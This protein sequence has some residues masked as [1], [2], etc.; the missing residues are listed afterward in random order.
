[1]KE[2]YF[3]MKRRFVLLL[4]TIVALTAMGTTSIWAQE[5]LGV[6]VAGVEVTSANATNLMKEIVKEIGNGT[7]KI[8]YDASTFTLTLEGV[9]MAIDD[10]TNP[11][12]T[13]SELNNFIIELKGDN[14]ITS[15]GGRLELSSLN[16]V[17]KGSGSLSYDASAAVAIFL[18]NSNLTI[19]GGCTVDVKGA[20]GI[21]G[22]MGLSEILLQS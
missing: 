21:T 18:D 8:S 5:P 14:V 16:N 19:E 6:T 15:K 22:D 10:S 4:A 12:Q 7:G 3:V 13:S 9:K 17:I 11:I 1:M 2:I 20:W